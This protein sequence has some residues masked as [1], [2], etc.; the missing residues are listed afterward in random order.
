MATKSIL[1]FN[2][3]S[4]KTER[5][6]SNCSIFFEPEENNCF[7]IIS[8]VIIREIAF[9]FILF[10]FFFENIKKSSGD[11]FELKN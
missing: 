9:F 8:H 5:I 1:I 7:N 4:L 11:H 6:L 10:R 3:Y 2:N